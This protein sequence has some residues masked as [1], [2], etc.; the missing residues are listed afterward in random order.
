VFR[1]L[2][3]QTTSTGLES[4]RCIV[5]MLAVFTAGIWTLTIFVLPRNDPPSMVISGSLRKLRVKNGF[6]CWGT[7]LLFATLDIPTGP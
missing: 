3:G 6:V 2:S 7:T 4:L 5:E 1:W